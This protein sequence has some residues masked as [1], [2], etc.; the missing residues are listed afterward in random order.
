MTLLT[1]RVHSPTPDDVLRHLHPMLP[2]GVLVTGEPVTGKG[3]SALI[4]FS[5]P[6]DEDIGRYDWIHIGGAGIDRIAAALKGSSK[7]PILTRTIGAMGHQMAEYVLSYI[8]ADLQKHGF[9]AAREA[10]RDWQKEASLPT[11]LFDQTVAIF[12]TGPI[13]RGVAEALTPLCREVTGYSRS[14][15]EAEGFTRTLPLER[16]DGAD[17]VIAALPATRE[18]DGIIG[19]V[20]LER[21]KG[22]LFMN[23]GRGAVVDDDALLRALDN[24]TVR[25]AILDV[26]RKEPL[27]KDHPYWPH[28]EV[29]VTPHVSGVT[30]PI[31]IA[32]AFAERLPKFLAK[33]L[34]S[35]VDLKR[36]Y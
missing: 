32:E 6:D 28:P 16:F 23:I 17:I 25:R 26:F 1:L 36:G 19:K 34:G 22:A 27:P 15:R 10:E 35:E 11:Y 18:T 14:G 3:P 24:G 5:A 13:G 12:G 21:M 31:D 29:T 9:R 33:R 2:E 20:L 7:T 8:L 30:R 4:A